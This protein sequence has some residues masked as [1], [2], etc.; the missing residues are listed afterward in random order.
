VAAA[1]IVR[2]ERLHRLAG[3]VGRTQ[4]ALRADQPVEPHDVAGLEVHDR[5]EPDLRAAGD[6]DSEQRRDDDHRDAARGGVAVAHEEEQR[7]VR[8]VLARDRGDFRAKRP[9]ELAFLGRQREPHVLVQHHRAADRAVQLHQR[10]ARRAVLG[11]AALAP[12][13]DER[14]FARLRLGVERGAH[15]LERSLGPL[16]VRLLEPAGGEL[17]QLDVE[18]HDHDAR[19]PAGLALE[20][21]R[22]PLHR[23]GAAGE[24]AEQHER[25]DERARGAQA[26]IVEHSHFPV[27]PDPRGR[28]SPPAPKA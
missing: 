19:D 11:R 28:S 4:V 18:R 20:L 24:Q 7:V 6:A 27:L 22:L 5:G 2:D 26:A 3:G 25:D 10:Q 8:V 16:G 17:R 1:F 23:R 9:V 14:H 15:V 21:R 13:V 12:E